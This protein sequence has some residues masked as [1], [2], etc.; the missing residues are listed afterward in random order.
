MTAVAT[1]PRWTAARW[2][3]PLDRPLLDALERKAAVAGL[4][5]P[6]P[7]WSFSSANVQT[8]KDMIHAW[9]GWGRLPVI[10]SPE[11]SV[12]T[13][14]QAEFNASLFHYLSRIDHQG[15][16]S[17]SLV[18]HAAAHHWLAA[19]L[20][21]LMDVL[22]LTA[23]L[24][25]TNGTRVRMLEI[26]GGWGRLAEMM[27]SLF[28][29]RVEYVMVDAVPVSLVSADAYLRATLP[30][31]TIGNYARGDRY[32]I[33]AYDIYLIPSWDVE[34]LGTARFDAVINIESFQEMTHEQVTMYLEWFDQMIC[35][36]GI[37]YIAN[38]RDYVM[39]GPW[40]FP[41]SW[42]TLTRHRT[43]RSWTLDNSTQIFRKEVGD[44]TAANR[45]IDVAYTRT[46]PLL[47]GTT[48]VAASWQAS[49]PGTPESELVT[50]AAS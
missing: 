40:N 18:D 39:K 21:S 8:L 30:N 37:A 35:D 23:F 12:A 29:G 48:S 15:L 46:L 19:D 11:E 1:L 7:Q 43:P 3:L 14:G 20:Y 26:G 28:P 50:V 32:E 27:L 22:E 31:A 9:V 6:G 33:G 42:R 34:H 49:P 4:L 38:S 25:T 36:N 5:G 24:S 2:D 47:T 44:F 45:I 16:I 17:T 41:R 13:T 10:A